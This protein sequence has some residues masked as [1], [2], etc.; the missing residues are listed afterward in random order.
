MRHKKVVAFPAERAKKKTKEQ[1]PPE[2]PLEPWSDPHTI[3][4][5]QPAFF[6]WLRSQLRRSWT[7]YPISTNFKNAQCRRAPAGSRAKW[8]GTCSKC[9][10]E[11]AKSHLQV[12]HIIPAGSLCSWEDVAGFTKRLY[13]T[14]NNLRLLCEPCHKTITQMDRHGIDEETWKK[15]QKLIEFSKLHAF[16]QREI[17]FEA[18]LPSEG[19]AKARIARYQQHLESQ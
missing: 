18:N 17:L 3:W 19:N 2:G 11:F 8:V 14:S 6:S 7:R 9:L 13:T 15:K 12:D 10:G 4:Q 16:R 1:A 5:T